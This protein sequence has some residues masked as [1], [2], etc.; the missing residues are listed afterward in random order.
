MNQRSLASWDIESTRRV[1]R[2]NKIL[3]VEL[4]C[5]TQTGLCKKG[6]SW[7]FFKKVQKQG[8]LPR[9]FYLGLQAMSPNPISL[10]VRALFA[11][12]GLSVQ[13]SSSMGQQTWRRSW[14][15]RASARKYLSPAQWPVGNAALWLAGRSLHAVVSPGSG[16]CAWNARMQNR[17]GVFSRGAL[18][19]R[20][21]PQQLQKR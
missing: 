20:I 19:Y 6:N 15:D 3:L 18:Q 13:T 7:D 17:G 9:K 2:Y 14:E 21:Q 16:V 1:R 5:W 8:L 10:T 12:W 11:K 4:K